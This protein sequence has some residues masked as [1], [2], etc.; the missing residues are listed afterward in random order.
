MPLIRIGTIVDGDCA[1]D[2]IRKLK[3]YGFES[4]SLHMGS[5]V[6]GVDLPRLA[7]SV[8]QELAGTDICISSIGVYGNPLA[9]DEKGLNTRKSFQTLIETAH[10]FGTDLVTGFSGAVEGK[11]VEDSLEKYCQIFGELGALAQEKGVRIAFENC[12]ADG[13]WNHLGCNMAFH[14]K[15]WELMFEALP[16]DNIGLQWEPC[17]QIVQL[18]DP[19]PQLRKWAKR[20]FHVHGK[21]ATIARDVI[22]ENGIYSSVPWCWHRTP[23]FGDSNWADIISIL[24]MNGFTGCIDIEGW[25]DPVYRGDLEYTGQVRALHYLKACRGEDYIQL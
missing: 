5:S 11:S 14:P 8:R 22:V 24:M 15:A 7:E 19:I 25:H 16:L 1:I 17:H 23:G 3:K 2:S 6:L 21:D 18:I 13:T 9:D 4:F 10:L 20:I 12:A